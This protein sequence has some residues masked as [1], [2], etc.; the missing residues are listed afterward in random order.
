G[1]SFSEMFTTSVA[2][3]VS[4]IPEGLPVAL[5]VILALG[6]QRILKKKGLVRKL[7]AA[8]TLGGTSVIAS[9]KT[10]TLTEGKMKVAEIF[11]IDGKKS[12]K[13]EVLKVGAVCNEAFIENQKDPQ[14]N[15]VLIGRPTDKALLSEAGAWGINRDL[16]EKKEEKLNEITFD[17]ARKYAASLHKISKDK[18]V[19]YAL[20]APEKIL[21]FSKIDSEKKKQATE[22]LARLTGK[23][24]RVVASAKKNLNKYDP[25]KKLENEMKDLKFLGLIALKDPLRMDAKES[26]K[27]VQKAGIRTIIVTGDHKLTAKNIA[28]E[29]GFKMQKDSLLEGK[30]LDMLSDKELDNIL[31][32][33]KV[34]ARVEPKHKIRI[35][36]AWQ[37]RGEVVAMTGDG[38]NDAPA[39][40]RADIGVALGSGTEVA[41]ETSDLILL[42]DNFSI[43]VSA[44]EEGRAILDNIRKVITY[45]LTGS[46]SEVILIAGALLAGFPLPI[47]P[48]QILW[49]NLVEDGLPDIS[50]A[51]E[52]KEDDLMDRKPQNQNT[53]LLTKEMKIII[54]VIGTITNFM[55]LGLFFWLMNK[56]YDIA[57]VRTVIFVA[58]AV[59]SLIYVFSLKS[60]RK[61]L[62]HINIFSNKFLLAAVSAGFLLLFTAVYFPPFQT[63]LKT[64][65]LSLTAW[66]AIIFLGILQLLLIE[67]VKWY[68]IVKK[69]V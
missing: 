3:A 38:I 33:V 21:E 39:L 24:F 30:D 43:I 59:D 50:L 61:N 29:L 68:F 35:V 65:P 48:A 34:Y 58:L 22:Q 1:N 23:G 55:V 14:E 52:K 11:A 4:A 44:I 31:T 56:G 18:F 32:K 46:F 37:K 17:S 40:K 63:L 57:F 53:P 51:F 16:I 66:M 10:C 69:K 27:Q 8:E 7:L 60:L 49:I 5:T 6:M 47:L 67:A 42:S 12:T 36:E 62:W 26:I 41:K 19:I 15:W 2:V 28:E 9:D 45:L 54:F 25:Q 64:V 20:G 13:M